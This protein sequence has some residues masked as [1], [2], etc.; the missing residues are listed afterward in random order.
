MQNENGAKGSQVVNITDPRDRC[1]RWEDL[2]FGP[3]D[4]Q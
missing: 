3:S 2:N 1:A 4:N